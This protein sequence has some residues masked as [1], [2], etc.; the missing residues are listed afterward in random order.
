MRTVN[1][2]KKLPLVSIIVAVYN[3]AR[4][5]QRC[6]N[7][8]ASQT[9]PHKELIIMDGG[10]TDG[11][12]DILKANSDKIAYWESKPD[13]GIYHAWNKALGH[14]K[15]D[16]VCFLGADDFFWTPDVLKHLAPYLLE[17]YPP[18]RVIY[19][20]VNVVSAAGNILLTA[21]EPWNRAQRHF[22]ERMTIP[23]QAAMHHR[24]LFEINGQFDE[25]FRII[26]DHELLMREFLRNSCSFLFVDNL[27]VTGMQHGGLSN[28]P[29]R[30]LLKLNELRYARRKNGIDGYSIEIFGRWFRAWIRWIITKIMGR[31]IANVMA[32]IYRVATGKP[33]IWTKL[34]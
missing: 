21:G 28:Q 32:D 29:E 8:V 3:S 31:R 11:T 12:V 26:G 1:I 34:A 9:Y 24:T 23:H 20:R 27:V 22:L 14:A 17:A 19:G 4:T 6:I 16:W 15:G 10:S 18:Y 13:R 25:S 33:R 2:S 7:S 30:A 5:L